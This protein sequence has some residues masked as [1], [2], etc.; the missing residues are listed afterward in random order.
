[1]AQAESLLRL[2]LRLDPHDSYANNFL[3]TLFYLDGNLEAALKYWNRDAMPRVVEIKIDPPLRVDPELLDRSF[4]FAPASDL[5][6]E[7]YWTTQ[8]RL[9]TLGIFPTHRFDLVPRS[10]T[11]SKDFDI[12]FAGSERNGWGDSKLDGILSVARGVPYQTVYPEFYNLRHSAINIHSLLRWDSKKR[13]AL[14]SISGPLGGRPEWRTQIYADGRDED[15]DVSNSLKGPGTLTEFQFY[16]IEAGAELLNVVNGR[17]TWMSGAA[18]SQRSFPGLTQSAPP[19]PPAFQDTFALEVHS[20]VDYALL[21]VPESRFTLTS[22]ASGQFGKAYARDLGFFEG[23]QGTLRARWSPLRRGDD[24]EMVGGFHAGRVFGGV[25]FDKLFILGLERDNDLP[26]RAHIGTQNGKKG[27]APLGR[28]YV[29]SNWEI[30]KNLM[31]VG[32]FRMRIAPF[33]DTGRAFD[34]TGQFGSRHWYWDTG[35]QLKFGLLGGLAVILTYGKDLRTGRNT[36]Y[37]SVGSG[38]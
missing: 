21:R 24:Y 27:S 9:K 8:K 28:A 34:A 36:F 14:V 38:D 26:L 18:V 6:L 4:A 20:R 2:A 30:N 16:T 13:R 5:R 31:S 32:W 1:M 35:G 19:V 22:S 7:D 25:P 12:N 17:L 10:E 23:L 15:W 29:L 33:L 37:T 3:A 11:G